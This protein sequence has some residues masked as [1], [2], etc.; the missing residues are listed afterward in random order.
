MGT[1]PSTAIRAPIGIGLGAALRG[2]WKPLVRVAA[3][4]FAYFAVVTA[5]HFPYHTDA[6]VP[7][8]VKT[9]ALKFY[10]GIYSA[11]SDAQPQSD[12]AVYVENAKD[13]IQEVQIVPT[14]QAFVKNF[15]LE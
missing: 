1:P 6:V 12:G 2:L 13:A 9:S 7:P 10:A 5:I 3:G 8:A 11:S 4:Y 15:G 14:V